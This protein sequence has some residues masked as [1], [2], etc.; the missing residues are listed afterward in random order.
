MTEHVRDHFDSLL[1]NDDWG[2]AF[3][4]HRPNVGYLLKAC[5]LAYLYDSVYRFSRETVIRPEI[6][7]LED[8]SFVEVPS[9]LSD[10]MGETDLLWL[11]LADEL[12]AEKPLRGWV[13]SLYDDR[14]DFVRAAKDNGI[15]L[16]ISGEYREDLDDVESKI[17]KRLERNAH[18]P[19]RLI[20]NYC[21]TR[22]VDR[23]E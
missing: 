2:T 12:A 23:F 1:N 10:W 17:E 7:G 13:D 11:T 22:T 15:F 5:E 8:V 19:P 4:R 18:V 3:K 21:F 20:H 14:A 9:E 16:P 6:D